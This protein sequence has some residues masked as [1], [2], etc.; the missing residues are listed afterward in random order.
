MFSL[1]TGRNLCGRRLAWNPDVLF[2]QQSD[3]LQAAMKDI[4]TYMSGS[5]WNLSV[6]FLLG[7]LREF[8]FI[9]QSAGR[10]FKEH[11]NLSIDL[12][13]MVSVLNGSLGS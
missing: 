6:G 13:V 4:N 10:S 12:W 5:T 8:Y 7:Y 1:R 9:C 3:L 2:L 11:G